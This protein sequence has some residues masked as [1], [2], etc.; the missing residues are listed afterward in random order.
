MSQPIY[1]RGGDGGETSLGDGSR[2]PKSDPR[3]CALGELDEA[4]SLVGW[5]AVAVE[6][7][8]IREILVFAQQRLMNCA[9]AVAAT[10]GTPVDDAPSVG[11]DDVAALERA[12]DS[13]S[14]RGGGFRG[15]VLPGGTEASA[16]LHVA[17]AVV[18]RA[19]RSLASLTKDAGVPAPLFAFVN[20]LSDLLFAA[21]SCESAASEATEAPWDPKARPPSG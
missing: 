19:E 21:A 20:R 17:R 18:R 7:E 11:E 15:F 4:G 3:I 6:D 8:P 12:I 16:R 10:N 13:L 2:S 1:S 5:A 9:C 14:E